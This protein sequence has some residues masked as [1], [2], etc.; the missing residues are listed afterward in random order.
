MLRF[1]VVFIVLLFMLGCY[2]IP[3]KKVHETP[4][5]TSAECDFLG[6]V[7]EFNFLE[8]KS[9]EYIVVDTICMC[10]FNGIKIQIKDK[11]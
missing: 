8:F 11:K 6:G 5:I 9:G 2:M 3:P 4:G 10:N 7:I 1:V